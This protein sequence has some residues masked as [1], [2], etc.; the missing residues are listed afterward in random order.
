VVAYNEE[1]H[2]GTAVRSLLTQELPP[3]VAWGNIWVVASGCTDRTVEVARKLAEE[4]SRICVVVEPERRGK[5][6]ALREVFD[7]ATGDALVLLNADACAE[8]GAVIH[9]LRTAEGKPTPCAVMARPVV[10]PQSSGRWAVTFQWM[11]DLHH[12]FHAA[13]LG[14]GKGGHL[15]DELL[16]VSLPGVTAIPDGI[17]ND[18]SYLAVWLSQQAGGR[19][20]ADQARVSI[21]VPTSIA[22]HLRQRRR[23]HVGNVQVASVLGRAPASIPRRFVERPTE[24]LRLL[25]RMASRPGGVAHLVR[26]AAWEVISH[27]L[28]LWD[29]LPPHKDHVRWER[30]HPAR[31][32]PRSRSESGS[33]LRGAQ[34]PTAE[35]EHRVGSIL[36]VAGEFRSGV[37]LERLVELLP[38]EGPDSVETLERWLQE[39][40]WLARLSGAR[41]F[42]PTVEPPASEERSERAHRYRSY[43]EELWQGPY[44]FARDLVRCAGITGSVAYGEPRAGDDLDMFIVTRTG[45]LWW[46]LLRAYVAVAL[47]RRRHKGPRGPT[48][49]LNYVLEDGTAGAEFALRNDQIFAREAL[50]VQVLL[51]ARYFRGLLASAPWMRAEFPR[52]YDARSGDPGEIAARAAPWPVRILN[53]LAFPVVASYLQV[54]G[55]VRN[56]R[57]RR[58]GGDGSAFRT[59]TGYR[60]LAFASERF[61]RLRGRYTFERPGEVA[62]GEPGSSGRSPSPR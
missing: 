17:I 11:W 33:D 8:Q 14:E 40:P 35:L 7:R 43:A 28:A 32:E 24:T 37:P 54:M 29:R 31:S 22:D 57:A 44:A 26:I 23:I 3:G 48:P 60:R 42:L 30:I 27:G 6:H 55:L 20:Y 25:G 5:A 49:C 52:L 21:E 39:R 36:D 2:L 18:G 1:I 19:W 61:E 16:M 10:P 41:A 13:I 12:E 9:L 46:F 34:I 62:P 56:A 45:A 47:G 50:N 4:D 58:P 38:P 53:F 15:S 59:E 51:G